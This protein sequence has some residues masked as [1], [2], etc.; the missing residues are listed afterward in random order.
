MGSDHPLSLTKAEHFSLGGKSNPP[1]SLSHAYRKDLADVRLAG[2]VIASHFAEGV[3]RRVLRTNDLR[4]APDAGSTT[5]TSLKEGDAF[6]MLDDTHG[7]AWG[8]AGP[9]RIV[10]YVES[11][12]LGA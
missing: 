3:M 11:S 6:E 8:Y 4:E 5:L 7:W 1:D 10:G 9:D 2:R 12:A